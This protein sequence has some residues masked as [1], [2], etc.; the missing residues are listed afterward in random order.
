MATL[1]Q[2]VD[3]I[4]TTWEGGRRSSNAL[5]D[6][7]Y[8]IFKILEYR[9]MYIRR[10]TEKNQFITN[11]IEQDLG[12]LALENV[13]AADCCDVEVGCTVKRTVVEIPEILRL[14]SKDALTYV[15]SI[16]KTTSYKI[17]RPYD[18]AWVKYNKYTNKSNRAYLLNKKI[19]V[20]SSNP[21]IDKINARGVF[22]D[23]RDIRQFICD[24]EACY[25]EDSRFPI[26]SDMLQSIVE[27]IVTKDLRMGM[28]DTINNQVDDKTLLKN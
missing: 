3:D 26:P 4:L 2:I 7:N 19:Y 9:A 14:N 28:T 24:G 21:F 16:D 11:Q 20:I 27:Q 23:P 12:C 13:D 15:G 6:R 8:I 22:Y 25:T 1:K 17:I 5:P 10:D 18:A